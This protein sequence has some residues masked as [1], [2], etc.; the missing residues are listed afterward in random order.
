MLTPSDRARAHQVLDRML[1]LLAN[2]SPSH[3]VL[4]VAFDRGRQLHVEARDIV[5]EL[6]QAPVPPA[7]PRP[8]QAVPVHS[9]KG[10]P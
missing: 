1:D 3:G 5:A 4:R 6:G 9:S 2:H 10:R 7:A 8:S